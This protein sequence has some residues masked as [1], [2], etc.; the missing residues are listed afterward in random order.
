MTT[1]LIDADSLLAIDVGGITTRVILFDVVDG[2]YRFLA[3]GSAPTTVNAPFNDVGEGIRM[4]LDQL[5]AITGRVLVDANEH[6]IMPGA[7]DGSGVDSIAA[8]LSAGPPLKVVAVGLL[9]DVSL[10]SACRMANTTY[11][12]VVESIGLND[13][14]KPEVRIDAILRVRPDLI[15]VAGGTENGASKSVFKLLESVGLAS[16]LLPEAQRPEILFAGNQALK[17]EIKSSL[18]KLTRLHFAPN[19]RP[20]LDQERLD[21]A[22]TYLADLFRNIRSRQISGVH[23]L[24]TLAGGGLLPTGMAFGRIIRFLSKVYD[25][26]KGVLGVDVGATAT[27]VAAAFGGKLTLG[28][29]PQFGLGRGIIE[30]SNHK[31]LDEITRWLHLD[32]PDDYIEEYVFTKALHPASLPATPEDLAI[33][34][35]LARQ[36]INASVKKLAR[37]FPESVKRS[38]GGLLPWFEPIVASGSVLTRAPNMARSLLMLL[39]GLQPTGVT[40]LVLDQNHIAP[41]LGA[42]AAINP[43]LTV[44]V[45]ESSTFLNLGTVISP[46]GQARPGTPILRL[47]MTLESGEETNLEVKQDALEVLPLPLGQ[48][49]KLHLQPLHRYDIGMGGAGRGGG[50]KVVGGVVGVIIDARGRPLRKVDDPARRRE[51]I[52]KWLWALGG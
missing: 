10:E 21:A 41:A 36:A 3:S 38:R 18:G 29:Y 33:E 34:E 31:P 17:E 35:A 19:V 15:L 4:A 7:A 8:T 51:M 46:V 44:Q 1:S 47:R 5:Q 2:R 20:S 13:R 42:A 30:L 28:I 32:I 11:A 24:N 9:E 6:F 39:D 43:I 37:G 40:T 14:L 22:Q 12:R 50:L 45:I 25:S 26:T 48:T 16:F 49:A 27:T 23:E 52:N